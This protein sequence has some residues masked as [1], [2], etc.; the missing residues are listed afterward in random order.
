[1]NDRVDRVEMRREKHPGK[2]DV[3]LL[4]LHSGQVLQIDRTIAQAIESGSR[5]TKEAWSRKLHVDSRVVDLGWSPD[6]Q[7][8]TKAMP[9]ILVVVMSTAVWVEVSRSKGRRRK[10]CDI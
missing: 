7:G 8:M 9:S 3:Y 1:M 5:I 2:D 4:K 10:Y 6:F